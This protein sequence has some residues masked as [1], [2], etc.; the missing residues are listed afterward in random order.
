MELVAANGSDRGYAVSLLEASDLP[1]DLDGTALYVARIDGER[2]G[3]GGLE[4]HGTDALLRSIAV[5]PA[6]R[7]E[8]FGSEIT[9]RLCAIAADRGVSGLYLLTTTAAEFFE[10][11]GFERIDRER[12]PDPIA[13]TSQFTTTCPASAVSMRRVL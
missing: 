4:V 1:T 10:K 3:C 2:V 9:D 13:R 7:G 11:R 8:G 12:V 6:V 5:D